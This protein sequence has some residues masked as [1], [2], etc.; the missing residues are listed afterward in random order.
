MDETIHWTNLY[1]WEI[2][3]RLAERY[4]IQVSRTVIGKLLKK[5]QAHV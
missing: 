3:Q 1:P 5:H 2:A 4:E